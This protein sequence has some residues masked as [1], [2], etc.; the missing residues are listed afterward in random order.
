LA[1]RVDYLFSLL[2]LAENIVEGGFKADIKIIFYGFF[3]GKFWERRPS[4]LVPCSR[5]LHR[6]AR[7]AYTRRAFFLAGGDSRSC[8]LTGR[9]TAGAQSPAFFFILSP[10]F[11]RPSELIAFLGFC[12]SNNFPALITGKPGIG[13][14]KIIEEA[15]AIAGA[16]LIIA[17]PVV[18]DPTDFKGLPFPTANGTADF[19]PYG[20]LN[21]IIKAQEPLVF[22]LDDLGQASNAVQAA[23]M[24]LLLAR[25]INGHKVSRHVT[26][27]AATNRKEDRAG[28]SGILEPVKSRFASIVELE[29]DT[30]DWVKWALKNSM[31]AELIAFIKFRPN[32]LDNSQ[33]SKDIVN[34]PSPRT[35]AN[36]GQLQLKGL[37]ESMEYEAFKGA[38]GQNFATEYRTFLSVMRNLPSVD[39]IIMSPRTAPVPPKPDI[40]YALTYALSRK[41]TEQN[42]QSICTYLDRMPAEYSVACIKG[43][44]ERNK[45]LCNTHA[46]LQWS[47]DHEGVLN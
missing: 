11:M 19:L 28:V 33:P 37:P 10:K 32:M 31:P 17:H 26:F 18:S 23:C 41:A 39:Q 38:A 12:I 36:V 1:L 30:N 2:V 14:S 13:K 8:F 3:Y 43:A 5:T 35:V 6:F 21:E 45:E 16:R 40:C 20:D 44:T 7:S 34:T 15:A 24:Q 47:S 46:F 22:F 27:I 42:L 25:Q 4:W 9:Y 29:V